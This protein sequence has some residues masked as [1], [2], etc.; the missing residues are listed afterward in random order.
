[1]AFLQGN[2]T[3]FMIGR[4]LLLHLPHSSFFFFCGLHLLHSVILKFTK[5]HSIFRKNICVSLDVKWRDSSE[6]I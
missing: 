4:S 2:L 1:M 3:L 5:L 6:V